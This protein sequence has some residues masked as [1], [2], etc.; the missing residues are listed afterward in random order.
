ME[1]TDYEKTQD[2]LRNQRKGDN[3]ARYNSLWALWRQVTIPRT[4]KNTAKP[5]AVSFFCFTTTLFFKDFCPKSKFLGE[6]IVFSG[7]I[8]NFAL[9]HC[10]KC[11]GESG[12]AILAEKILT[13]VC[14]YSEKPYESTTFDNNKIR[15]NKSQASVRCA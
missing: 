4:L 2:D 1:P 8:C 12:G 10:H 15:K 5:L 11:F 7:K 3:G 13:S 14:C 9:E 6:N